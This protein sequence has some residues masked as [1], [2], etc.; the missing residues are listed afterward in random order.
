MHGTGTTLLNLSVLLNVLRLQ[1]T[2]NICPYQIERVRV[3][4]VRSTADGGLHEG[5]THEVF[6]ASAIAIAEMSGTRD[7]E[8]E[9]QPRILLIIL[10]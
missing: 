10:T 9:Q 5:C 7:L 6:A 1:T 3:S 4:G 8:T 2:Y